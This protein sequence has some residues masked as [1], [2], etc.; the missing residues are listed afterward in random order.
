MVFIKM[1]REFTDDY[2]HFYFKGYF[3]SLIFK[4]LNVA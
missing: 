3:P 2:H 1:F 4:N